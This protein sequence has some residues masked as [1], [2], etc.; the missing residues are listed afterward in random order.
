MAN[1]QHRHSSRNE[2]PFLLNYD[3]TELRIASEFLSNWLPFLSRGLCRR[4]IRTL[5][6]RIRS[7]GNGDDSEYLNREMSGSAVLTLKNM[8][9]NG[10]DHCPDNCDSNSVVSLKGSGDMNDNEDTNSLGSWK[11][12][13][14]GLSEPVAD[15]EAEAST[16]SAPVEIPEAKLSW[17]D[18]AQEDELEGEEETEVNMEHPGDGDVVTEDGTLE[19]EDKP[20]IQLSREQREHIRFSNVMRKTDFICFERV[21]G[22]FV[23]ILEGLELHTGVFSSAEQ[24]RIV[25]YVEELVVMGKNGQFKERTYTEP[26]KWMRGKGRVTIQFGC[27]YNYATDKKGN[28]PGILKNELVDPLPQLFK[29]MIKRLI[30]WHVLPP[31]CVPDSCIV[32]IYEEGDCIPPH[33]DNHEFLRPF[34]TVSFLSECNIVFGTNLKVVGPGQFAGAFA[35]PLRVGSVL[36][37][38]GKGA[39]VTKHCIPGVPTKRISITFRRM[40]ESKRPQGYVSEPDLEGLQPLPYGRE[41]NKKLNSSSP[42]RYVKNHMGRR[43]EREENYPKINGP[44]VRNSELRQSNRFRPGPPDRLRARVNLED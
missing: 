36:V 7:L 37:L 43:E 2:D 34:C 19:K 32:N 6:D 24:K 11:D 4:C 10:G 17:A 42:R 23:N 5:S 39:D 29:V 8:N 28:P 21:N 38:N 12:G 15:G 16:I 13:A 20:K 31:S 22:K 30:R 9:F 18:M 1:H 40:D 26:T 41:R 33:I 14:D 35:I 44:I 27:C 25:E 3:A